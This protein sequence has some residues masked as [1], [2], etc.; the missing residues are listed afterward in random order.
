MQTAIG[1][2]DFKARCLKLLDEVAATR[3]PLV[4]T[5]HGKAVAKLVPVPAEAE[6]FGAMAGSVH[7]EG[8]IVSPLD[9]EWEASR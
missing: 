1:A 9:N 3:E 6:L 8:D 2:G 5:K 7:H 4:I